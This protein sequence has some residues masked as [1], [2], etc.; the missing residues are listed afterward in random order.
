MRTNA[1]VV[2]ENI[3][4]PNASLRNTKQAQNKPREQTNRVD[5]ES[6]ADESDREYTLYRVNS[7]SS[8][9]ILVSVALNDVPVDMELDTGASVSLISEETFQ[10]LRE[11]GATLKPSEAKLCTYTGQAIEVVGLAGM[12]VTHNEQVVTLPLYVTRGQGPSLLGRNWLEALRLDWKNI[13]SI[14]KERTV[15]SVLDC[16]ADVFRD[17]LGTVKGMTAMIHVETA[18]TPRFHKARSV[19]FALRARVEDE[20]ERLK[21]QGIIQ[22]VHFS[23]CPLCLSSRVTEK[24]AFVVTTRLRS[25]SVPQSTSIRFPVSTICSLR[26]LEENDFRNSR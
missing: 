20:L 18:A 12:K 4:H 14:R 19:P 22:P 5:D 16:Y 9:P 1:T 15:Q 26:Y 24:F 17:E 6:P 21:K 10:P 25:T 8:K 23:E 2:E 3:A 11:K 13:F 7:G